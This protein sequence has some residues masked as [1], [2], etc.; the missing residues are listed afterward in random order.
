MQN[1]RLVGPAGALLLAASALAL[2]C[3]VEPSQLKESDLQQDRIIGGFPAQDETFEAIGALGFP[4]T[5]ALRQSSQPQRMLRSRRYLKGVRLPQ[6]FAEGDTHF[7][8]CSG[9]LI[10][11]NAVLTAEHCVDF[12]FG[13]EV[14]MLGFNGGQP[15]RTIPI[16]GRVAETSIPGG[17]VGYGSDIAIAILA[18]PIT[19]V[20]PLPYGTLNLDDIGTPFVG[21]G[22][23]VRNND[24]DAG[25]RYLGE[26]ELKG[27]GGNHALNVWGSVSAYLEHFPEL[28]ITGNPFSFLSSL[29]LIFAYEASFGNAPGDANACFGDSGGPIARIQ[30]DVL[31]VFGVT[32]GGLGTVDQICD[33]GAVYSILGP[34]ANT[35][36]DQAVAC[37]L[38]PPEGQCS[39]L[40]TVARCAP[41]EEGGYKVVETDCS[42]LG[43]ICGEGSDGSVQC[44]SDPC[45]DLPEEGVC[46]G[47]V[48]VTCED[49]PRR[50]V[51]INCTLIGGACGLG[52]EGEVEC[53]GATSGTC[54]DNCGGSDVNPDGSLC[55]CD[56]I[57][58]DLGDCCADYLEV[59]EP[60]P[61]PEFG[62][63]EDAC[64]GSV[65]G[66]DGS[67]CYCDSVCES[68]GDCCPD[69]AD[70]CDFGDT[71]GGTA[72]T[73]FESS[74]SGFF[75]GDTGDTGTFETGTTGD[76]GF[77]E[78]SSTGG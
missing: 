45:A 25:L 11:P 73:G 71:S 32:S 1:P 33:W 12:L 13:D 77:Y 40:T 20:D 34:A 27:V 2:D 41:P 23:G 14:F 7:P 53:L 52:D 61:P 64:G 43:L 24:E 30:N 35:V 8:F 21:V 68:F 26:M 72:D 29:N 75:P 58:Q 60:P 57:C 76:T 18:E 10:A 51:E 9:T 15:E 55:F 38:V 66:P 39:D 17:F 74:S 67:V 46:D 56:D 44:L 28:G 6:Q 69:F 3:G 54:Q 16:I 47:D 19:D 22:Y 50:V 65:T 59:C 5:N 36:V 78:S 4:L 31:T 42:L 63:C 48:A 49:D 70:F 37:G 62:S